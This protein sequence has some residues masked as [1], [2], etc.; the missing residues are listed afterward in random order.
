[1][2]S[3]SKGRTGSEAREIEPIHEEIKDDLEEDDDI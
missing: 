3:A 2:T 1:M